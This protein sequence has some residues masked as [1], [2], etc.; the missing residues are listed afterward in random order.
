MVYVEAIHPAHLSIVKLLL[1]C[2]KH[3]L[4]EKPLGMNVKETKEMLNLAKEKNLFLMEAIWS[5]V[6]PSYLRLKEEIQKG[7]IGE[8]YHVQSEF[9]A[10]I[11]CDRMNKKEL[12]GGACLDI[13]IYCIQLAQFVFEGEKPK[14]N[15]ISTF[16]FELHR[17]QIHLIPYRIVRFTF[18]SFRFIK[19]Y[20]NHSNVLENF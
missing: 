9:G 10:Y 11:P 2:E 18:Q 1:N 4:C 17:Y 5:R 20:L 19:R 7:S 13:G 15:H 6:Q 14:V 8:V 3:I 16:D 12:G